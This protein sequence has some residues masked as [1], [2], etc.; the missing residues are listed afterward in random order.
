MG[1][2]PQLT[3]FRMMTCLRCAV[4]D[5]LVSTK[6]TKVLLFQ[7][8]ITVVKKRIYSRTSL[9][10]TPMGRRDLYSLSGVRINWSNNNWI[11]VVGT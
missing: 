9:I 5:T 1:T 3:D 10:R 6:D 4:A 2:L 8:T 11:A 7:S